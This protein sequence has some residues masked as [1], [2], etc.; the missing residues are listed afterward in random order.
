MTDAAPDGPR[1]YVDLDRLEEQ[2]DDARLGSLEA[3]LN[4]L[5]AELERDDP[6]KRPA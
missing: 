4:E 3:L 1:T 5:E 2:D 6:A